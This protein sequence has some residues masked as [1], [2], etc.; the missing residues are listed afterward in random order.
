MIE[1]VDVVLCVEALGIVGSE[2][3]IVIQFQGELKK[4]GHCPDKAK[5][6]RRGDNGIWLATD[7][8]CPYA[9]GSGYS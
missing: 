6:C 7:I 5:D 4:E 8:A 1:S 3:V 2:E 9:K